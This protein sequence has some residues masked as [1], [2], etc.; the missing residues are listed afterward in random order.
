ML[1]EIK[2]DTSKWKDNLCSHGLEDLI[3]LK[4]HTSEKWGCTTY[5]SAK[6][7]YMTSIKSMKARQGI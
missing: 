6:Q 5:N 7:K 2:A 3:L 1:K 4:M